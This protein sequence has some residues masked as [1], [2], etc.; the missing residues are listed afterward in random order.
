MLYLHQHEQSKHKM[1]RLIAQY[2][3]QN[4]TISENIAL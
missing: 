1:R 2:C 3:H 4:I